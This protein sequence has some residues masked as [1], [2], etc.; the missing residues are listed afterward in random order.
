MKTKGEAWL[1]NDRDDHP[2]LV[3]EG[4]LK[5]L[6]VKQFLDKKKGQIM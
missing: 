2:S 5:M 4:P 3:A 1:V 6:T